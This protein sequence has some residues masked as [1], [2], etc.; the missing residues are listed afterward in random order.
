LDLSGRGLH[1]V[2]RVARSIADLDSQE[3]LSIEHVAEA[4][5]LRLPTP[6]RAI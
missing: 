5:S 2:L 6:A 1:R 4:L 3:R